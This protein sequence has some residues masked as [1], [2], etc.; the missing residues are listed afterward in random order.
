MTSWECSLIYF[1]QDQ[2]SSLKQVQGR[3]QPTCIRLWEDA[4]PCSSVPWSSRKASKTERLK[5]VPCHLLFPLK[6][7][8]VQ[9]SASLWRSK[10]VTAT[11]M[12]PRRRRKCTYNR[13]KS[14]ISIS[15]VEFLQVKE[16]QLLCYILLSVFWRFEETGLL[17]HMPCYYSII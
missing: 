10:P 9:T 14:S 12:E 1:R 2:L 13:I 17:S 3:Q 11:E 16:V 4:S 7:T 15:L 8:G 6:G 5:V